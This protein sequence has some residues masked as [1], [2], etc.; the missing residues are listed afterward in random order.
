MGTPA[1]IE[2][3]VGKELT[4][5]LAS[6]IKAESSGNTLVS[7]DDKRPAIEPE[8]VAVFQPVP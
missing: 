6:F 5:D 1:Q 7:D 4:K 3:V 8:A 2:K